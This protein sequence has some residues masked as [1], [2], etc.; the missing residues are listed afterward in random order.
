MNHA[1][2]GKHAVTCCIRAALLMADCQIVL[3]GEEDNAQPF[4]VVQVSLLYNWRKES[5]DF[6]KLVLFSLL[7]FIPYGLRY[8]L[9]LLYSFHCYLISLGTKFHWHISPHIGSRVD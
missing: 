9:T 7:I 6:V 3:H 1:M 2:H 8:A 4:T 5:C